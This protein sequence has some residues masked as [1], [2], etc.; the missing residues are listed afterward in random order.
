M[1]LFPKRKT[2]D[3]DTNNYPIISKT[4]QQRKR[5]GPIASRNK[6]FGTKTDTGQEAQTASAAALQQR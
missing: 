4:S 2:K 6:A 3:L 5:S 1:S